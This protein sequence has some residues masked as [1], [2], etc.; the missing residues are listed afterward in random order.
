MR[1]QVL[2][3]GAGKRVFIDLIPC[4]TSL[5]VE[6]FDIIAVRQS[7]EKVPYFSKIL[8]FNNLDRALNIF[9]GDVIFCCVPEYAH[10]QV[11]KSLKK[12]ETPKTIFFDTPIK[13]NYAKLRLLNKVHDVRVLEETQLFT[14]MRSFIK[15]FGIFR[16]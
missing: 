12:I 4:L 10:K 8:V 14:E 9:K 5:G 13:K 11:I 2:V 15:S 7:L 6:E 3:I 16:Y 1:Q